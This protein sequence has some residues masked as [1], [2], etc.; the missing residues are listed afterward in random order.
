MEAI[1]AKNLTKRYGRARGIEGVELSVH[2]GDFFGFIGP[3]GAGKSTTIKILLGLIGADSGEAR[4]LGLDPAKDGSKILAEVGYVSS[5][6]NF[7]A[8]MRGADVL[9]LSEALRRRDAGDFR[10]ALC[11]RL[12]F[13]DRK[14]VRELSFGNRKKLAIISALQ[15]RP[16]LVILDEP[17]S[18]LDPLVQHEFFEILE[19]MSAA[20]ATVFLSS[21]VLAEVQRYCRRT[22]IIREG[23]V[24]ACEDTQTLL[25]SKVKRVTVVGGDV[26]GGKGLNGV[27][28]APV[29]SPLEGAFDVKSTPAGGWSFLYRGDMAQLMEFLAKHRVD[30]LG[31]SEPDLDEVFM[32]YYV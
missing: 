8:E 1:T 27:A 3:N 20:G 10:E 7:H 21:H 23:K 29:E 25:G 14:R 31:I 9:R 15:H 24:V 5:E 4:V 30:D 18:G 22:A 17:T 13:D 11:R 32:H 6:S 28:A 12:Q 2:Q 16:R 26:F 19:E